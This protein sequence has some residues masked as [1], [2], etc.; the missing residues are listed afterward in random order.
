MS[1]IVSADGKDPSRGRAVFRG[2]TYLCAIGRGGISADKTEGDGVSPTGE[3]DIVKILYRPDRGAAPDTALDVAPI[4][5]TDGWC[6]D[7]A[8]ADYNRPVT[9]PHP[10]GAETLWRDDA[11]YDL[12]A[13]TSHNSNP[14]VPGAGSAIFVHIAG[15][16]D[17]PPTEG[18]IAFARADLEAILRDWIPG[19]DTIAIA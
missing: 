19:R 6:D 1:L 13:V 7:P 4:L 15:G 17:Y 18:C 3:F 12:V 10:A 11:L 14:V 5:P 9:L 8:H 16:A 2:R